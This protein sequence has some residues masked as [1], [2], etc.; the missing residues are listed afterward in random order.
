MKLYFVTGNE[1]KARE[2]ARIM[3]DIERISLDLPEIQS[4][5][6]QEVLKEKLLEAHKLEPNKTLV[7]EDVT[8]S[9]KGMGG[10]PGTLIKWF[11]ESLGPSG[12]FDLLGEKDST[13]SVCANLGIINPSGEMS[14]FVGEVKGITVTP[15]AG[16]GFHFDNIFMPDGQDKR[17]SEMTRDEKDAISH[18]GIAWQKLSKSFGNKKRP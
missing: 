10:L 6:P 17:Y 7:V 16:E 1:M 14:F 9:I 11:V 18:R 2:V 5:D 3:P 12:I 4:L 8:Y 15:G 13:T